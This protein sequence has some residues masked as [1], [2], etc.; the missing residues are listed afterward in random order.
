M[1]PELLLTKAINTLIRWNDEDPTVEVEVKQI[2]N[3]QIS[4]LEY[5]LANVAN[6]KNPIVRNAIAL[7]YGILGVEEL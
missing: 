1:H 2:N 3:A 6:R 4:I 5:A 7:A